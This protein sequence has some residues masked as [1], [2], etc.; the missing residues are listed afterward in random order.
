MRMLMDYKPEEYEPEPNMKEVPY[1]HSKAVE[2]NDPIEDEHWKLLEVEAEKQ[3]VDMVNSPPHYTNRKIEVI[4]VIED[5]TTTEG[6]NGYL[7][8]Q[9]LR[10]VLR[11]K[12]KVNPLED[13]KKAQ[14]YLKRLII[15]LENE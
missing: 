9:V 5:T 15:K 11:F 1:H 10:Y 3:T 13:L 7:E 2:Q 4:D 8:G 12:D 14:W 6:Y